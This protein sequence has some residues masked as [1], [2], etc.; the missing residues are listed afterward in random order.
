[1][2][3]AAVTGLA[4][5]SLISLAISSITM[6]QG[7]FLGIGSPDTPEFFFGLAIVLALVARLFAKRTGW[8][9]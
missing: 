5:G 1:M 4:A 3:Y 2:R 7:M 8:S 9:S 6:L